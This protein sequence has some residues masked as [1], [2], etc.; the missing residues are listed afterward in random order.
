[1]KW[2]KISAI[3]LKELGH[4]FVSP[5]GYV[6]IAI[7]F[8]VSGFFFQLIALQGKV[9]QMSFVFQNTLIVLMFITP[10]ITMRLWSEEEKTGTA[11]L[12]R[13]SPL[14]TWEIVLGKYLAILGFFVVMLSSTFVY[15]FIMLSAGNPDM[16]PVAANY[17]GYILVGMSFFALG[18]LAST[19]SENQIISA[20]IAY[21]LLLMLWIVGAASDSTQGKLS[22][23]LKSLSMFEH[24]NDFM[25]GVIDLTH[26]FYFVSLIFVGLFFSVK[27]LD[28]KRG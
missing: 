6:V 10:F 22:E 20:V 1:M 8:L 12:L 9:A 4:F 26:V 13:T 5:M 18:L 11:E 15:L 28:G 17:L 21:G 2:N 7:F 25:R 23:F 19:L 14:T 3:A 24:V 16:G 27:V